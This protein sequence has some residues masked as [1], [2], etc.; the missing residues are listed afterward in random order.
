MKTHLASS[1]RWPEHVLDIRL[2]DMMIGRT[3]HQHCGG[4]SRAAE[5]RDDRGIGRHV[6]W[7]LGVRTLTTWRTR[8]A[9][10]Q[11]EIVAALIDNHETTGGMLQHLQAKATTPSFVTFA[12]GETLF[13]RV[14]PI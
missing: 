14:Q 9:W 13:L 7:K 5:R 12:G 2:Y 10:S 8:I 11:V 6:P 3:G 1:Q 4:H